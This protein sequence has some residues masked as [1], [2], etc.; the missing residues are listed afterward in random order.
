M[1]PRNIKSL[2]VKIAWVSAI[3]ATCTFF[4]GWTALGHRESNQTTAATL[5]TP[6]ETVS[7]QQFATKAAQG[8]MAEV[9]LGELAQEK[10][11][12]EAVKN[13]GQRMV[14]D[15]TKANE[16]LKGIASKENITLPADVG[17]TEE[18]SYN[19]LSKLSGAAFDRAYAQDMVKDHEQDIAEFNREAS[20]GQNDSLKKFASETLPTL[21]DHLKLAKEM[22]GASGAAQV[23]TRRKIRP[24]GKAFL[25]P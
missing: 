4:A 11:S 23:H 22:P 10:G 16:Q 19:A 25:R 5:N 2:L 9:K 14:A 1:K 3:T 12:S 18:A 7:D 15:H 17:A 20:G 24:A 21:K 13:F 6:K 8:G